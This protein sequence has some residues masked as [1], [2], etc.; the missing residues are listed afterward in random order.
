MINAKSGVRT[1]L[2][3]SGRAIFPL[4]LALL[5]GMYA[6]TGRLEP[7]PA[8]AIWSLTRPP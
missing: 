4:L 1:R 8:W 2:G 7:A 5:T 6:I 3:R